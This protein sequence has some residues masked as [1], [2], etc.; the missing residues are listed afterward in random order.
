MLSRFA[1]CRSVATV[2][3][4]NQQALLAH[5]VEIAP[6]YADVGEVTSSNDAAFP[7]KRNGTRP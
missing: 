6:R 3:H 7:G 2:A 1:V 4:P 5:P